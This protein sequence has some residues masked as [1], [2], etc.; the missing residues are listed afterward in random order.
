MGQVLMDDTDNRLIV[1][2]PD[3]TVAVARCAIPAGTLL[4]IAGQAV[5]LAQAV[6]MGH[7][8]ARR[9]ARPG[10][11]VL[12]Y[13]VSIGSATAAIAPGDHVHLHNLQSDYTPTYALTDTGEVA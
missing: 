13:G 10:D 9:A 8:V 5:T 2:H 12:K 11:K 7:K 1:L 6:T 3:D 4:R